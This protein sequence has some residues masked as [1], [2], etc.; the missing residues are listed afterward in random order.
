MYFK[1]WPYIQLEYLWVMHDITMVFSA[2]DAVDVQDWSE[3]ASVSCA[4]WREFV[5]FCSYAIT[6]V[7]TTLLDDAFVFYFST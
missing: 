5:L 7:N 1:K 3:L 6:E 4:Q 2:V